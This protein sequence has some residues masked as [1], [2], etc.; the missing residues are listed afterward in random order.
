MKLYTTNI[1]KTYKGRNVVDGVSVEVN[2][3]EIKFD[4]SYSEYQK[5]KQC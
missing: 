5:R 1:R 4:G 2:Q 3:G